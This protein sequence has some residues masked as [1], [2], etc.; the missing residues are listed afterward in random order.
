M[1]GTRCV[2]V[3]FQMMANGESPLKKARISEDVLDWHSAHATEGVKENSLVRG[4]MLAF[5]GSGAVMWK[6]GMQT[7]RMRRGQE[8]E[9]LVIGAACSEVF[10]GPQLAKVLR[11]A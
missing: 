10:S 9:T 2:C 11:P 3:S 6:N 8:E 5:S 1:G 4:A 7:R